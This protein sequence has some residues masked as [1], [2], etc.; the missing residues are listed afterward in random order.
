METLKPTSANNLRVGTLLNLCEQR[1]KG[2]EIETATVDG[3]QRGIYT[4]H[5]RMLGAFSDTVPG[6]H[7][8]LIIVKQQGIE[9][10]HVSLINEI[11]EVVYRETIGSV[12]TN[13][14][15][16]EYTLAD[17]TAALFDFILVQCDY[18]GGDP[19]RL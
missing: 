11:N 3:K 14:P 18:A 15:K 5:I 9:D 1:A 2:C 19:T 12:Y 13:S 4:I 6:G 17:D 16:H 10:L 8:K 7:Y